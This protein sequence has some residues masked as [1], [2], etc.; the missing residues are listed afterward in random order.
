MIKD[1]RAV[2]WTQGRG[3]HKHTRWD[4]QIMREG[5]TKWE[6]LPYIKVKRKP[7]EV[8]KDRYK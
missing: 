4:I 6:S 3:W 1:I 8:S 2:E 5:S 7:K